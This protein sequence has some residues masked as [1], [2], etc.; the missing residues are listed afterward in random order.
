MLGRMF[1]LSDA[2]AR[3]AEENGIP[4]EALN[5]VV[6]VESS[7]NPAAIRFEPGY[8]W[9]WDVRRRRAF[10]RLTVDERR[11]L[12]PPDDF[13]SVA[14]SAAT[15]WIG[16]RISWGACQMMGAVAR[17]DGFSGGFLSELLDPAL[18][19]HFG[20]LRLAKLYA[21]HGERFGWAG[22]FRAYNTGSPDPGAWGDRY[23]EKIS[24]HWSGA[25]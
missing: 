1:N 6:Q 8:R 20:A 24:K 7:G 9:L 19:L 4:F 5:A 14:G 10:R 13:Y 17:E 3:A 25:R 11:S 12:K 2:I 23:L 16:Q 18:N 21:R 15:E 22:A